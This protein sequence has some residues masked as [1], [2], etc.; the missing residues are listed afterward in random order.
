MS[1]F[2]SFN[3]VVVFLL[4]TYLGLFSG[5]IFSLFKK[6]I[7]FFVVKLKKALKWGEKKQK[8]VKPK[9]ILKK[10]KN[11]DSNPQNGAKNG[12]NNIKPNLKFFK[13]AGFY[14]ILKIINNLTVNIL[15]SFCLILCVVISFYFNLKLNFGELRFVY[16][17]VWIGFFFVGK[18]LCNLLANYFLCFYNYFIKRKKIKWTNKTTTIQEKQN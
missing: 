1:L 9:Q 17:I 11:I 7:C 8:E 12:K 6:I 14:K 3:H 16:V 13:T 2:Y 4:F 18:S 10:N 15:S 5:L